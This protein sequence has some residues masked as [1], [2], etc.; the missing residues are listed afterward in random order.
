[1][2]NRQPT[3]KAGKK[4]GRYRIV[5]E[6]GRGGMGVV[7][8]AEDEN[9]DR[10]VAL[11][12]TSVSGL[13]TGEKARH[14][15]RQRFIREVQALAQLSHE[16][17]VHVYD[18]GEADDPDLGWVL[19]Y[20]MQFVEGITLSELVQRQGALSPAVAAAVCA[21]AAA[22][23]GAAHRQ[24]IIHR[25]VKPANIFLSNDGRALIG[26][27]G[28]AKIE[29]STQITRRDQLV[30]TPNY[31]APEQILGEPV[32]AA[33]DVFA[34]GALFFVIATN[35]PLRVRLDAAALLQEAKGNLASEKMLGERQIPSGLRKVVAR[36]LERDASR[37]YPD[38][39]AFAAAL[40]PHAGRIPRFAEE[41]VERR[42]EEESHTS[43]SNAFAPMVDKAAPSEA[44]YAGVEEAAAAL[45]A[46][47][48]QSAKRSTPPKARAA[49][50]P[51]ARSEST[52]MFNL[53]TMQPDDE[54][55]EVAL[56]PEPASA[57]APRPEDTLPKRQPLPVAR[58]ESTVVYQLRETAAEPGR[59]PG[60][61]K[62]SDAMGDPEQK[63]GVSDVATGQGG[64]APAVSRPR[65]KALP[66]ANPMRSALGTKRDFLSV[67]MAAVA[68]VLVAVTLFAAW[69]VVARA[70]TPEVPRPDPGDAPAFV[71]P[72]AEDP[73]PLAPDCERQ[74]VS[75]KTRTQVRAWLQEARA[76]E[77]DQL[78]RAR[79]LLENAIAQDPGN[80]EA[81]YQMGRVCALMKDFAAAKAEYR[82]VLHLAGG[83]DS[84]F[85][86]LARK[87][88]QAR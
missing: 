57:M 77:S 42:T 45:L 26:D 21:Q 9:L 27:F 76:R 87:A 50:L 44:G 48:E 84:S 37:R 43:D 29:G 73:G 74:P 47:F 5:R 2:A 82:C 60:A 18:A 62:A 64:E 68:G 55:D 38:C 11:K 58:T 7:Y 13:G 17:V 53:R 81:H 88:L 72:A 40:A 28:I 30:G 8:L 20:S 6:L 19:F 80:E 14:Q 4:L 35:R 78:A 52:V 63:P 61:P 46:E 32:S 3:A 1:M 83:G 51:V 10:R 69:V 12:T 33:T 36:A 31:L 75:Q 49:P 41:P 24:G 59:P 39:A 34:L 70:R 56:E 54:G 16:N 65:L 23:L 86:S 71:L 22:G 67:A 85:A 79:Q 66:L 15:R 25:D